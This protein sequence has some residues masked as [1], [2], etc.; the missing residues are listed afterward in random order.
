MIPLGKAITILSLSCL[1]FRGPLVTR[2][3]MDQPERAVMVAKVYPGP[4]IMLTIQENG[5][6]T[7]EPQGKDMQGTSNL[8]STNS[9]PPT[10]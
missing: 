4:F 10:F 3:L 6:V 5:V 7:N 2:I 1:S 8:T 9:M